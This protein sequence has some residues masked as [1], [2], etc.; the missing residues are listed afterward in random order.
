MSLIVIRLSSLFEIPVFNSYSCLLCLL[1]PDSPDSVLRHCTSKAHLAYISE[2]LKFLGSSFT[3]L[4]FFCL[5]IAIYLFHSLVYATFRFA[6]NCDFV[7]RAFLSFTYFIGTGSTANVLTVILEAF[8]TALVLPCEQ[9]RSNVIG[10]VDEA[11]ERQRSITSSLDEQI[12]DVRAK[13]SQTQQQE[14]AT[15]SARPSLRW[16]L[17]P[18]ERIISP[19]ISRPSGVSVKK[20]RSPS[21]QTLLLDP[22]LNAPVAATP[23]AEY[24]VAT[25]DPSPTVQNTT[26]RQHPLLITS[27]VVDT[28][29]Y[30][31]Y[32]SQAPEFGE[33]D[34]GLGGPPPLTPS[35][36]A[37]ALPTSTA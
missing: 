3:T 21:R 26:G 22:P 28:Q 17:V 29:D 19:R 25:P 23:V 11:L 32:S 2:T 7:F 36:M 12:A 34:A 13:I 8:N 16:N 5:I 37:T 33:P 4:S 1:P 14:A 24:T 9:T 31:H 10:Q 27:P 18:D 35:M 30:P 20:P 6:F 15:V